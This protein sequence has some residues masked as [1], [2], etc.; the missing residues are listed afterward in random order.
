MSL[1]NTARELVQALL[2]LHGTGLERT[3]EL[4]DQSGAP[5]Q[6]IIDT[7]IQDELV[8]DALLMLHGLHPLSLNERV[9]LALEKC[10]RTMPTHGGNVEFLGVTDDGVVKLK[11]EGSCHTARLRA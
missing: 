10:A 8:S 9:T 7:L 3:L 11:L 5:G 6:A 4:I 2:D 1:Q